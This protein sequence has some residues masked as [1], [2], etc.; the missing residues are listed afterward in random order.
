[1]SKDR[2][3]YS[4]KEEEARI[5]QASSFLKEVLVPAYLKLRKR[6]DI[7]LSDVI[8]PLMDNYAKTHKDSLSFNRF[9]LW[10][11]IQKVLILREKN[12]I[13]PWIPDQSSLKK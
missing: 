4:F 2:L 10:R 5:D 13:D 9:E 6:A 7:V 8:A 3:R 12:T 11:A 1:M